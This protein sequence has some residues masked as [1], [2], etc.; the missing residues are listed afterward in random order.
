MGKEGKKKAKG[1]ASA[2]KEEANTTA[3]AYANVE[4][5]GSYPPPAFSSLMCVT[6]V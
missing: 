2:P 6:F 3:D 4:G 5:G 1:G